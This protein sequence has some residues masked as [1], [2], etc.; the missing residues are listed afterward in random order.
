[1]NI[2]TPKL[3]LG[4]L[5]LILILASCA[6]ESEEG[7]D[8][9]V[10]F[11]INTAQGSRGLSFY[12]L[13]SENNLRAIPQDPKNPLTPA[14]VS[15]GQQLFHESGFATIGSFPEFAGTY[16]CASCHHADGG[17]Q[18][19]M[20]QGIGDGGIGFG[21]F[22]E[23]RMPDRL[24]EMDKIDVQPLRT[25]SALNSAYQTNLLWN[26]QFGATALNEGT[27]HLWPDE[28][29][30]AKNRLGFEG[31]EIQAIAGLAVHRHKI[32]KAS[33]ESL[34]YKEMF[35]AA[36]SNMPE[37]QR[38]ND[39]Q[40]GLAIAAY[41]RT[42][43]ATGAPFQ[44]WLNGDLNAMSE[45]Q[46]E[47]A[48][49]FFDKGQCTSCHNGP[50]LAKMEFHAIGLKDFNPD[51]VFNFDAND[52]ANL[53]RASF[54]KD[55]ADNYKFKVPQLYNLKDS[56]FFGHGSSFTSVRD[57]IAYKNQAISENDRVHSEQ[58]SPLFKPLNLSEE[59]IN[60][61]TIFV[62]EALYDPDLKR[63]EPSSVASGNCFPN[64]DWASKADLGCE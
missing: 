12:K 63:F 29:P 7:L 41:E 54:T 36:F 16:S 60:L 25:P 9:D 57:I 6:S 43:L 64:N 20:I 55:D 19:N 39:V 13:P 3:Y 8:K 45:A 23:G 49:L 2:F 11:A 1:M 32:D 15:L 34:G 37:A 4:M 14:K 56:P 21:A 46:K 52:P 31:V 44:R 18:A 5:C 59:E 10:R 40:A 35:D 53:G 22:G 28:T 30:I 33:V 24:I 58:L 17:F 48:I 61:L 38:Y 62:E 26:G 47:G 27:E 50:G 42:L 51:E